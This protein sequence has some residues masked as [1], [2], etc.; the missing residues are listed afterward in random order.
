ML[1][2]KTLLSTRATET[3]PTATGAT[4]AVVATSNSAHRKKQFNKNIFNKIQAFAKVLDSY[5]R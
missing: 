1:N 3:K 5:T 2:Y 4:I